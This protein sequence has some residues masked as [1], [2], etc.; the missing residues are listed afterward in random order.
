MNRSLVL[1]LVCA[2]SL[3][4]GGLFGYRQFAEKEPSLDQL[5]GISL[6]DID[7]QLRHGSEWLGKVV[8]LNH[9]ATWCGPCREEIPLLVEFNAIMADRDVQVL[10]VAHD[11]LDAAR[12]FGDEVGMDYPSLVAI[13]DGH[14]LLAAQGNDK[15]GALPFT[16]VFDRQGTIAATKLGIVSMEDL[17]SMVKP[18]L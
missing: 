16:V 4:V 6:P 8:V 3:V 14:K 7:Q 15:S 10:G 9:W 1:V 13:I 18:L 17:Q 11:R 2:V 5:Q 12:R